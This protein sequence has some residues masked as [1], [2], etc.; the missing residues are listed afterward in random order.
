LT[1]IDV[2]DY[3]VLDF[4]GLG[5]IRSVGIQTIGSKDV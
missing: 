1:V 5:Y 3:I 2:Q 4:G